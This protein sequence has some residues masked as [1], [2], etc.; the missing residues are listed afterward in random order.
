VAALLGV[1]EGGADDGV[2][3]EGGKLGVV[4]SDLGDEA[5]VDEVPLEVAVVY[6]FVAT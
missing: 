2:E 1:D 6:D 4:D 5:A 3:D